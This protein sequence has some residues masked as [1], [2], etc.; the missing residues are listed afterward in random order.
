MSD[1]KRLSGLAGALAALVL[2]AF[3][4]LV[5][6]TAWTVL[7]IAA[8]VI[9]PVAMFRRRAALVLTVRRR[10][11]RHVRAVTAEPERPMEDALQAYA[12]GMIRRDEDDNLEGRK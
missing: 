6:A 3:V 4:A 12:E 9:V 2:V 7:L 1:S 11:R 10:F 8:A 5:I